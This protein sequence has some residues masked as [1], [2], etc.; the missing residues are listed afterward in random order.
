MKNNGKTAVYGS[1][2]FPHGLR[3]LH[4]NMK[5][6]QSTN[7]PKILDNFFHLA[8]KKRHTTV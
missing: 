8:F 7:K 6:T 3:L 4:K 1:S 2:V 5:R